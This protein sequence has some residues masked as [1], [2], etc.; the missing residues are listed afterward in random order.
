MKQRKCFLIVHLEILDPLFGILWKK[1]QNIAKPP[2]TSEI[3]FT[4]WIQLTSFWAMSCVFCLFVK[5][6][7]ASFCI[8][9]L[10]LCMISQ[11]FWSFDDVLK[12]MCFFVF[13]LF[14]CFVFC[15]SFCFIFFF[16]PIWRRHRCVTLVLPSGSWCCSITLCPIYICH[17]SC[18]G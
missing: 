3:S 15:F 6:I 1:L 7:F 16:M 18:F 11:A 5:C 2:N 4:V 17:F 12:I 9:L 10:N 13:V 8:F 14:F